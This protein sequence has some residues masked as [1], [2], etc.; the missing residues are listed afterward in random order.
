MP[1]RTGLVNREFK[2]RLPFPGF[3]AREY[4]RMC[5]RH[6]PVT[7]RQHGS[8]WYSRKR[9]L[10]PASAPI[11]CAIALCTSKMRGAFISIGTLAPVSP[12]HTKSRGL[13]TKIYRRVSFHSAT[14]RRTKKWRDGA[15]PKP[16]AFGQVLILRWPDG[17]PARSIQRYRLA[18]RDRHCGRVRQRIRAAWPE[19]DCAVE[20]V[21]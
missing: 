11:F 7:H 8:I 17:A 16:A 3:S 15:F 2:W 6:H 19:G 14:I 21:D 18:H 9:C 12:V 13:S 20:P 1:I 4:F 5:R 10:S